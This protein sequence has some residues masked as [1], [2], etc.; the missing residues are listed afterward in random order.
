MVLRVE[1]FVASTGPWNV[2]AAT[3]VLGKKV[4]IWW[5]AVP[6]EKYLVPWLIV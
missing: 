2:P 6:G 1:R 5:E 4:H 3:F